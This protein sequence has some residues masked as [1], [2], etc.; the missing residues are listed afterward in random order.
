MPMY[1]ALYKWTD[2]GIQNVKDAPSRARAALKAA[3]AA[4]AKNLGVWFTEGPYDLVSVGEFADEN[5]AAAHALAVGSLGF[6]RTL[7]MRARTIDEFAEIIKML[8]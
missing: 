3:K 1:V 8:P 4:G 7:S 2:K 6:V 5:A